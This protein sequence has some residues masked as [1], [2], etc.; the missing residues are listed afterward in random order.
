MGVCPFLHKTSI[1]QKAGRPPV[2]KNSSGLNFSE[3]LVKSML[4]QYKNTLA[5]SDA[6]KMNMRT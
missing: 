4:P 6:P 3:T 2:F 1:F 5:K